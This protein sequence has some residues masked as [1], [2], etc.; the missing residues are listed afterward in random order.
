MTSIFLSVGQCGNQLANCLLGYLDSNDRAQTSYLYRFNDEKF[1]LVGLDGD[2]K[3]MERMRDE[4]SSRV[5]K[6]NLIGCK[7][8][9]GS[10]WASGYHSLAGLGGGETRNVELGRTMD[11]IRRESERCDFLLHFNLMHSLAGGAGSGCTS[12][13]MEELRDEY[14]TKKYMFNQTVA[15][16][17][18]GE[19]P[20]Q[21]YNT[22]LS[23]PFLFDLSDCI[24]LHQNDDVMRQIEKQQL[25]DAPKST[26]TKLMPHRLASRSVESS[27]LN[28]LI[29]FND[30]NSYIVRSMLTSMLPVDSVSLREQSIGMELLEMC[31]LLCSMPSLKIVEQLT[32]NMTESSIVVDRY[33]PKSKEQ[34]HSLM[35]MLL[36]RSF[37]SMPKFD[38][39]TERPERYVS[40]SSLLIARSNLDTCNQQLAYL[41]SNYELIKRNLNPV[42]WNPHS[43]EFWTSSQLVNECGAEQ[44]KSK[45]SSMTMCMNRTRCVDYLS[46]VQARSMSK[47]KQRAYLHWYEEFGVG[48]DYFRNGFESVQ[49]VIDAYKSI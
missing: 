11:A 29:T 42:K 3:V 22:L 28:D 2:N 18:D 35:S 33:A 45:S 23:L 14:G 7:K 49:H 25:S 20:L 6:E 46:E 4:Q 44:K 24:Y 9:N 47:Y 26:S 12:R 36:K 37:G 31:R 43:I 17:R 48:D 19:L 32:A 41:W 21:H 15:P 39:R 38:Q 8:L 13:L 34:E 16:F 5:R 1:R 10:L 40:L 30:M 27:N